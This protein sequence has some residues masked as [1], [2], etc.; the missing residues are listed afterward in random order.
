MKIK[1]SKIFVWLK[2]KFSK[3]RPAFAKAYPSDTYIEDL[4]K[5]TKSSKTWVKVLPFVIA[6]CVCADFALVSDTF[7]YYFDAGFDTAEP[8]FLDYLFLYA[9]KY[10]IPAALVI[11][12][13]AVGFVAGKHFA[14]YKALGS[15]KAVLFTI[16]LLALE[17]VVLVFIGLV[18]Y[19][20]ILNQEIDKAATGGLAYV[21]MPFVLQAWAFGDKGG[22]S[23][24]STS[25]DTSASSSGSNMVSDTA[26]FVFDQ[27]AFMWTMALCI[28]MFL[29]AFL[30]FLYS[31]YTYDAFSARKKEIATQFLPA[32]KAIFENTFNSVA[33]NKTKNSTYEYEENLLDQ[34]ASQQSF[35]V[36]KLAVQLNGIVDPADA[37]DFENIS[38]VVSSQNGI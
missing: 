22:G 26:T 9:E 36:T 13:L 25:I 18:R 19:L 24:S 30:G 29:G 31:Y 8:G 6:I 4:H 21:F 17:I 35:I 27:Q 1:N 7:A 15:K 2:S 33:F 38:K 20:G 10:A 23:G 28:I 32:D 14:E 3:R 16:I 12:Y 37:Y 34:K 11:A 5:A